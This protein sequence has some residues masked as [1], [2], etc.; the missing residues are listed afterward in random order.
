METCMACMEGQVDTPPNKKKLMSS[1]VIHTKTGP[2]LRHIG[3]VSLLGI[4]V[5]LTG[6]FSKPITLSAFM[7]DLQD[8]IQKTN[9]VIRLTTYQISNHNGDSIL[10]IEQNSQCTSDPILLFFHGDLVFNLKGTIS[11][12][13]GLSLAMLTP[14]GPSSTFK[15]NN[16]SG[17]EIKYSV[18]FIPLSNVADAVFKRD[19]AIVETLSTIKSPEARKVMDDFLADNWDMH[20]KLLD[21]TRVLIKNWKRPMFCRNKEKQIQ[22]RIIPPPTASKL[23]Q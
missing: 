16:A 21:T 17:H 12:K 23:M 19:L 14:T 6:C 2:I 22:K 15:I 7:N 5:I 9:P 18:K 1:D 11:K 20:R 3:P 10:R 13:G 8:G 4:C